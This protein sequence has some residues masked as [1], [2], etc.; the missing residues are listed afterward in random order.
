[1]SP[2]Q[3]DVARHPD[4]IWKLGSE[5]SWDLKFLGSRNWENC[6]GLFLGHG[7]RRVQVNY[8]LREQG[9]WATSGLQL[10]YIV[11]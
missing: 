9:G 7:N 6:I 11:S 5:E 8:V 1:M 2:A 10:R 4:K 3:F